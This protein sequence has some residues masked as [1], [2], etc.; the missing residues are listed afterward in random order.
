[1]AI[2]CFSRK[3]LSKTAGRNKLYRGTEKVSMQK[4]H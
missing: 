3:R 2:N 1:L 4:G